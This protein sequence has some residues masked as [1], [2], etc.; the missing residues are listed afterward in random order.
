MAPIEAAGFLAIVLGGYLAL[1]GFLA[2]KS[3]SARDPSRTLFAEFNIR[4]AKS[5]LPL[6]LVILAVG[7]IL[8]LIDLR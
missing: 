8:M 5:L 4:A 6:G 7:V 1:Y 3:R 2:G